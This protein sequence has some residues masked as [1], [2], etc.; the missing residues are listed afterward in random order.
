[1]PDFCR[2]RLPH[3][4]PRPAEATLEPSVPC[5][6]QPADF[7]KVCRGLGAALTW[8][9]Q[10]PAGTFLGA[11]ALCP[12]PKGST[13]GASGPVSAGAPSASHFRNK[14]NNSTLVFSAGSFRFSAS[15]EVVQTIHRRQKMLHRQKN[16]CV[17]LISENKK[18]FISQVSAV[19]AF[20]QPQIVTGK[21]RS[22]SYSQSVVPQ[23]VTQHPFEIN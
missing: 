5:S 15:Q 6:S 9:W 22:L 20:L 18:S 2:Q 14:R 1:M 13:I 21:M 3:S 12:L 17:N 23:K 11:A 19:R 8:D 4:C 7:P 10:P 16:S